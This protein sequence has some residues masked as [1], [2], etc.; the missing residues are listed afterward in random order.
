MLERL[1]LNRLDEHLDNSTN[2][3]NANQYGFR[4]GRSTLD[5]M[6]RVRETAGWA[7]RG[8][9]QHRDACILVLIDVKNAFNSLPWRVIDRALEQKNTPTYI[10]RIIRSYLTDRILHAN[11]GTV[12]LTGGGGVPQ[13]SV[14]GPTLWNA[15]YDELLEMP[16]PPGVQLIGFADDLALVTTDRDPETLENVT[17]RTLK[18]ID[19]WMT[20]K[21]LQNVPTKTKAIIL[22]KKKILPNL[23]IRIRG[24]AIPVVKEARYLGVT[25]DTRLSFTSHIN[26]VA[27]NTR[28][29]IAAMG[30]IMPNIGGPSENKRRL[31]MNIANSRLLYAAPNW[32][33]ST[34]EFN[35]CREAILGAQR[36][37]ATRIT[38]AYQTVSRVAALAL[39]GTP[40]GQSTSD[41]GV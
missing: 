35:K 17:N 9:P 10:R 21:G 20:G 28:S 27:N 32:A 34:R 14:L 38:R 2:G 31:L 37:A 26:N 11:A 41:R 25:F 7:N 16:T 8:P 5:A 15:V 13:E 3:R 29:I 40:P 12:E 24:Q 36:T 33:E 30:R 6:E 19:R 39:A 4:R 23:D 18:E 22:T 1:I